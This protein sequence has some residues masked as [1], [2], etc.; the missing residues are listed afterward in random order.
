MDYI[1][2]QLASRLEAQLA[3]GKS[4]LLLGPRQTG[5][6]T[7]LARVPVDLRIDLIDPAV[8]QR[9]EAAPG[10]LAGELAALPARSG[11]PPRVVLD[12]IQKVP[13]LLD[14]VQG[15]V[16]K[17]AAQFILSG[18]SARKLRRG[19]A[20][21]LPGRVVAMRL[22]PLT[23]D[24]MENPQLDDL[25]RYGSL[26]AMVREGNPTHR[27]DDLRSYVQTYLEQEVRAEAIV[28]SV[29]SFA[30][31][32]ELAALESGNLV[33]FRALSQQVG[34][35][36]TTIA[37]YFEILEDCLVAERVDPL[38]ESKTRKKLT[39]SSRWI[40]FDLGVRRL[41]ADEGVKLKPER[42]GQLFEQFVGLE[43]IRVARR[44]F[45]HARVQ[46]WRDADGVE[47]DW[48][49]RTPDGMV[50]VEVKWN[51]MPTARDARHLRVFMDEYRAAAAFVICRVP[52]PVRI[53]SKI[54]ALPWQDMRRVFNWRG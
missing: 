36:H 18:S 2:R 54:M 19:G 30:R 12:E 46:F 39:K 51:T 34:V 10:Q 23:L 4:I 29:G 50:P 52:R 20:N 24:E 22:D 43:L 42:L 8:R 3:R 11:R 37:S 45:P 28:R 40:L 27:D 14:V 6:T 41:A 33:S 15:M 5:K 48:V 9:Y 38:S 35:A 25:L 21:L 44:D 49:V 1:R 32:L 13:A 16:D 53:E 31:F 17:R 7:M 47:V 26:P